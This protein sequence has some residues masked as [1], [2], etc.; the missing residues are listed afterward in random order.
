MLF[1]TQVIE[2]YHSI[3][4]NEDYQFLCESEQKALRHCIAY[5]IQC[6]IF[7]LMLN[8]IFP[9]I[10]FTTTLN[11]DINNA[12]HIMTAVSTEEGWTVEAGSQIST[13][14]L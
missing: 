9:A 7:Q 11:L 3:I 1:L 4:K 6:L 5:H 13:A 14:K 12:Q 8:M 2:F 10:Q